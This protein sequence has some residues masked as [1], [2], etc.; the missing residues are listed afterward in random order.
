MTLP[1]AQAAQVTVANHDYLVIMMLLGAIV[2]MLSGFGVVEPDARGQLISVLFLPVPMLAALALG[3]AVGGHRILSLVLLAVILAAGTYLRRFGPRGVASGMLL[4]MGFFFGFFLHGPITIGD[5][6]WVVA[7]VCLG[8]AV[9]LVV[10]FG[11]FYPRPAH[12]LQ[13]TQRSYAA[14]AR[15]VA[16][17][18][19]ELFE[20][21]A[22]S[23]R[24][25]RRLQRHLVRL[26]EAALMVDAQLGDPAAVG[27]RVLRTAAP[28][29]PLRHRARPHQHRPLRRRPWHVSTCRWISA[30]RCSWRCETSPP[31]SSRAPPNT[32]G[33][34]PRAPPPP[35]PGPLASGDDLTAVVVPHRFAGS[36]IA[37][38][39]AGT[40]WLALGTM[41]EGDGPPASQATFEP[42]VT[43][44]GGWLPGSAQVSAVASAE[45]GIAPGRPGRSGALHPRRHPGGCGRR[46]SPLRWVTS[47]SGRRF[48]WAV[49]AAFITF[50]GVNNSGEQARK[51]LYRIAGTVVGIGIGSLLVTAVGPSSLLV[52]RGDPVVPVFRLLP[53]AHQLRLHGGGD[54][55]HGV[56]ALRRAGGVLEFAARTPAGRDGH[57]RHGRHP[58]RH[59]RPSPAHP[60][61]LARRAARVTCTRWPP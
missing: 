35:C 56:P 44:F 22:H 41:D 52:D 43:L 60:P 46:R 17:L 26:N 57:R 39:A 16:A 9:A 19:L 25:V 8:D 45:R 15:K 36:V 33:T 42:A 18:A 37:L 1:A 2:G 21:P 10:R 14:R 13:R 20:D 32:P 49:I 51:G 3:I 29:A 61:G 24:D 11:L 54:H 58:R 40:E 50:M 23:E 27:R 6:G 30:P 31:A 48:Y 34:L 7:A 38:S 47:L 53:D 28:S 55:G 4:F 5:L 12:A 59:V